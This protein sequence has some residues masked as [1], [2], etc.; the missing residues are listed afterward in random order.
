M[1]RGRSVL[2]ALPPFVIGLAGAGVAEISATLLL[3]SAEGFLPA[4]TL[5]LTVEAGAFALGL[6]SGSAQVGSVSVEQLRLRWLFALVALSLA[7]AF[8]TGMTVMEEVFRG[9]LWQG[10]GL[11]FLGSLP[12]FALGSLLAAMG[13]SRPSG[14]WKPGVSAAFGLA[15]G[16]LLTGVLLL[17]N[18]APYTFYLLL[19]SALSGGALLHG[20][21]LDGRLQASVVEEIPTPRGMARVEDRRTGA[22]GLQ[23]R[24][25]LEGGRV[26]ARESVDGRSGRGW[27]N[28]VLEGL[29]EGE[30]CPSPVLFLGGGGGTLARLLLDDFPEVD[31]LVVEESREVLRLARKHLRPF[32]GWERVRCEMGRPWRILEELEMTFPLLLVDLEAV[33]SLGP[34]PDIPARVWKE[35]A[36]RAGA[37]GLVVLGGLALR[38]RLG[39]APVEGLLREASRHFA[40]GV[41]YE[42]DEEAFL[43]ASG[44]RAPIWPRVLP[45]FRATVSTEDL[46]G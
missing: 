11:A 5:I 9:G 43:F 31:L 36:C 20:W 27:E 29:K 16:F 41:V 14:A 30:H 10:F 7:A 38:D 12:L 33:P 21:V 23:W 46:D 6:W 34:I 22:A 18:M 42:G 28:A 24:V 8:S 44:S 26:R 3:Y 39:K 4:L 25:I 45:G 19:L 15:A 2:G 13:R 32:P 40:T 17:P 37:E 35:M 1:S